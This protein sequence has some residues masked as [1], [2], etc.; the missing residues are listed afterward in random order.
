MKNIRPYYFDFFAASLFLFLPAAMI[1]G[2]FIPDLIVSILAI[3]FFF[4]FHNNVALYKN[5]FFICFIFFYLLILVSTF[6]SHNF[7][8]SIQTTLPYLRFGLFVL[9]GFYLICKF[10][11]IKI[12]FLNFLV[13]CFFILSVDGFCEFLTGRNILGYA[14]TNGRLA[15]LFG[16]ELI[17]GSYV[18]RSLPIAVAI[19]FSM[20]A[21]IKFKFFY[22]SI[23]LFSALLIIM[24]GERTAFAILTIFLISILC[25]CNFKLIL[26]FFTFFF[27]LLSFALILFFS[28]SLK[29][30]FIDETFSEIKG[31]NDSIAIH[32]NIDGNNNSKYNILSE[33]LL[34][35]RDKSKNNKLFLL[36]TAHESA[37]RISLKMFQSSKLIGIGPKMFRYECDNDLYKVYERGCSTHP[38]NI[39]AQIL[40]EVGIFGFLFFFILFLAA[41]FLCFFNAFF[42]K[43]RIINNYQIILICSYITI[44]F[45]LLPSGNFF[46]NWLS[47]TMYLPL[48][49]LLSSFYE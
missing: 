39:Y 31:S 11:K 38:H 28:S 46:N 8:I 33:E 43:K 16:D 47:V 12:Y 14:Y 42:L 10:P 37:W 20:Y 7:L 2:P 23:F 40:A 17:L 6:F 15:G 45:P 27:F 19:F 21:K 5:Y 34:A 30:R 18:S 1:T 29:S 26:K 48:T 9:T 13:F 4:I 25:F 22:Y 36:S 24:S 3:Y 35:M 32:K 41:S 44:L 49:F